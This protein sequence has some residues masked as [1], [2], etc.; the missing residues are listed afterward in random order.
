LLVKR[1][2]TP[3]F[4]PLP[5]AAEVMRQMAVHQ[6]SRVV[7]YEGLTHLAIDIPTGLERSDVVRSIVQEVDLACDAIVR[8][9]AGKSQT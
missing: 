6:P 4:L 2:A 9:M 3:N 5:L 7:E 8:A 1:H